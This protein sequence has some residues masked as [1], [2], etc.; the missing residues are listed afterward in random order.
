MGIWVQI[1]S[2]LVKTKKQKLG[3]WKATIGL[4]VSLFEF[5]CLSPGWP[6]LLALFS[7]NYANRYDK[8]TVPI[9][10]APPPRQSPP[11]TISLS[12]SSVSNIFSKEN[13]SHMKIVMLTTSSQVQTAWEDMRFRVGCL[14]LWDQVCMHSGV[15][16]VLSLPRWLRAQ[17]AFPR[18]SLYFSSK[19][20]CKA[21]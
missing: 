11:T 3:L 18:W 2:S 7:S 4:P 10:Y 8:I 19:D 5:S 1:L 12:P 6:L 15:M 17:T 21:D 9:V 16:T 14:E 20:C 13:S